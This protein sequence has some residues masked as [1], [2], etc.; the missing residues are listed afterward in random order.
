MIGPLSGLT[1]NL[2]LKAGLAPI[3]RWCGAA[4]RQMLKLV[5]IGR[6]LW[7]PIRLK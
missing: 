5:P 2:P 1:I 7:S 6:P 4:A 3:L